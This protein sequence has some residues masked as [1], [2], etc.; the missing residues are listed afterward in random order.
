M[1]GAPFSERGQQDASEYLMSLAMYCRTVENCL[2]NKDKETMHQLL[3]LLLILL[4]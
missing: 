1:L 3:I 4:L 2:N